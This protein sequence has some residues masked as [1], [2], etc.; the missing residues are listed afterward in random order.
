M[1]TRAEY[2]KYLRSLEGGYGPARGLR[3]NDNQFNTWYY[4]RRVSGDNYAW[5]AVTECYV[6]NHF[7][8]L[9]ING[10]KVAY[11]PNMVSVA[12]KAGAKVWHRPKSVPAQGT[13]WAQPGNKLCYDFNRTGEAEHTGTFVRRLSSTTFLASEG[14]TSTSQH[15]D[16]LAPKTR[17]VRDVLDV[18][19]L[20]GVDGSSQEDDM[21]IRT[22]LSIDKAQDLK[23]GEFVTLNWGQ[24][25]ADPKKAHADGE[26]PGYVAPLSSWADFDASVR[27]EGLTEGDEYQLRYEVHDWAGGKSKGD[28][29]TEIHA[30]AK[31]TN[32][33]QFVPGSCSKGLTKG[34]HCYVAVAVFPAGGDAQGRPAPKATA[35]RVTVRQDPS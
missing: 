24:E 28:P 8:I 21:P 33:A 4:G 20:L 7:G 30:D 15:S 34:Q 14:N 32:G 12:R 10:G 17:N 23:W 2:V 27:V 22:S 11:V 26:Y 1:P 19:E 6:E 29:W 35:G 9:A 18:I 16:A 31:A 3:N 13:S 25:N 5:C